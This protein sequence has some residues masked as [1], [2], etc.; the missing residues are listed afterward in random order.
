MTTARLAQVNLFNASLI[1]KREQF[2]ARQ[3]AA[4]VILAA[5][6]M[7]AVAVWSTLQM[8]TL[9]HEVAEQARQLAGRSASALAAPTLQGQVVPTAQEVA[10]L[11][12]TLRG[13]Q[14]SLQARRAARDALK[15][16]MAGP[17]S[18]PSAVMRLIAE[19]IPQAAWLTEI[20]AVGGSIELSG[21]TLDPEAVDAWLGRLRASG[22]LAERPAPSVRAERIET[23]EATGRRAPAYT[24]GIS[25]TLANPLAQEGGQP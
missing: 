25:G 18:G 16:G 6:A 24:F 2:S 9:R 4:G 5:V 19:S 8:R 7:I 21:R 23:S 14:S 15:R 11:E 17:D 3:I 10:A 22:L 1:P 20:R 12:Q 13:R